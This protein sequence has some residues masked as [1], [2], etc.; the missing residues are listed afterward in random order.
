MFETLIQSV[1][2]VAPVVPQGIYDNAVAVIIAVASAIAVI[3]KFITDRSKDSKAGKYMTTFGQKTVEQQEEM[4]IIA[5]AAAAGSPETAKTL[6]QMYGKNMLELRARAEAAERQL[7]RLQA[8]L[9]AR[10]DANTDTAI[11]AIETDVKAEISR[12]LISNG[13]RGREKEWGN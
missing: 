1:A 10:M 4:Y 7:K 12:Q 6:E 3:G 13:L 11:G 9:P 8:P 5:K 2:E